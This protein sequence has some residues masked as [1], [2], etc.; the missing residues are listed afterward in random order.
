MTDVPKKGKG[1]VVGKKRPKIE[2]LEISKETLESLT[3]EQAAA[4]RGGADEAARVINTLP[5]GLRN[6]Q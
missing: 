2:R 3:E 6:C 5:H 4:A 1:E